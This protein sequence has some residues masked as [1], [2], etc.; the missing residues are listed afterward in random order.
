MFV[1]NI[2]Y[3]LITSRHIRFVTAEMIKNVK[4]KTLITAMKQIGNAYKKGA[5]ELSK[6]ELVLFT[7]CYILRIFFEN[8]E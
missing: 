8:G 6:R 1:N 5:F 4:L 2:P 7:I 3:M